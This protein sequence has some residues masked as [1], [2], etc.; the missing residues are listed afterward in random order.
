MIGSAKSRA[1]MFAC[2]LLFIAVSPA[3]AQRADD[4]TLNSVRQSDQ[5]ARG[6]NG[7]LGQMTAAEHVRRATVYMLN[8]A[9]A[10]AREHWQAL[11]DNYPSDPNVPV[12]IFGIARSYLQAQQYEEARQTFE[13]VA[14]EYPQTKE[15]REGLNFWASSLLHMSRSVEAA[16]RYREYIER[17]PDGERIEN[18]YLNVIDCYREADQPRE[19]LNWV[20]R[21]RERFAGTATDTNALFTRLRVEINQADWQR[22]VQTADEL[23]SKPFQ[24]DVNT[25]ADE[26]AYLRAFSLERSGRIEDAVRAY[27]AISGSYDSY[28]GGLA[29]A[30]LSAM[31]DATGR[32]EAAARTQRARAQINGAAAG[33]PAPYRQEILREAKP[34]AVDPRLVLAIMKQESSFKPNSKSPAAARGL[35]QLTID[36]A[37]KYARRAGINRLTE[38]ALYQPQTSI[39]LGCEYMAQLARL[40]ANLPEAIAAA[41]N[42]GEDN[43]ARWLARTHQHD[44]GVFAADIGIPETKKYVAKVL[45]NY[46][47]YQQLYSADLTRR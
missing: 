1:R 47:A 39:A 35:L 7:S 12:A 34:R 16:D 30:R 20:N 37:D 41:Y 11:I 43:V 15:G 28:Y 38:E 33:F 3:L 8:R 17:Y 40:F 4:A 6:A 36:T 5:A 32:Q 2:L 24:R 22:A 44:S 21:T 19:A 31:P 14:R 9:F 29:T 46:H 13:K 45:A 42:S 23:L 10:E 18:A 25:S 27:A 26:V